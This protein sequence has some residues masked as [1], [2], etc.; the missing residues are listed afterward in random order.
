[1]QF[2]VQVV[3]GTDWEKDICWKIKIK[4]LSVYE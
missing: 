2:L 4:K 3:F 1:M